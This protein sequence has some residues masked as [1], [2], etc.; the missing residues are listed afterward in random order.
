MFA[1]QT[2]AG[3]IRISPDLRS[4]GTEGNTLADLFE[5]WGSE[6]RRGT[7]PEAIENRLLG[8]LAGP[9]QHKVRANL[10]QIRAELERELASFQFHRKAT[11]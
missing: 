10:D 8:T 5:G 2:L 9:R 4:E 3:I 7:P 6:L 1:D 11:S